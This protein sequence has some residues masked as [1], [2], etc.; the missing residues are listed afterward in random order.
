VDLIAKAM[1]IVKGRQS[2]RGVMEAGGGGIGLEKEK[3]YGNAKAWSA[4]E[5]E[6]D[7]YIYI[8]VLALCARERMQETMPSAVK[9]AASL[10]FTGAGSDLLAVKR[11]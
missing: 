1:K 6:A 2:Q 5:E 7:I 4:I 9:G 8:Y 3:P 10:W 11:A